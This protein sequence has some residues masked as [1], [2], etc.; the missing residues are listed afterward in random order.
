MRGDK[1]ECWGRGLCCNQVG[2]SDS[3]HDGCCSSE[4]DVQLLVLGVQ[5]IHT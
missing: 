3:E 2:G 1:S 5:D 4:H